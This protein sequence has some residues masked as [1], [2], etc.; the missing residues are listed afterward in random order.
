MAQISDLLNMAASPNYSIDQIL[1]TTQ[2]QA[3]PS[4]FRQVLG[5]LLGGIGNMFA[6]GIGGLLGGAI[7]GGGIG[8]G[9]TNPAGVFAQ[10]MQYLRLQQQISQ[11]QEVFEMASSIIKSRHDAA[12]A[13]IR[14]VN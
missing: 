6:P 13:A 8:G 5:G 11:E 3:Q 1:Q 9:V 2:P 4:G 12:L 10:S 14:N 7:G